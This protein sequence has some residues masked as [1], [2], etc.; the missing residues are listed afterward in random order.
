MRIRNTVTQLQQATNLAACVDMV[1]YSSE[2]E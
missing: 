1:V 2:P